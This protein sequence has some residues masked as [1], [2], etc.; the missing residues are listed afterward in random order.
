MLDERT[1][2]LLKIL[3]SK[4]SYGSY[5]VI[6][7]DELILDFPSRYGADNDLIRQMISNLSQ[8]GLLSVRYDKDGEFC[9]SLTPKGR[10]YFE[11]ETNFVSVQKST[12]TDL[13]PHL[14][15]FLSIF[16]AIFLSGILLKIIGV[17]C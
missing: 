8:Q 7:L 17:I 14:F 10:L 6:T 3:N 9:L 4:C 5:K 1:T 13:L 16:F 12:I 11:T 2:A 15:N